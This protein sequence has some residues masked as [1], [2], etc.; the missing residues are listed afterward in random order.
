V[1]G[2]SITTPA[3]VAVRTLFALAVL[4][5]MSIGTA[6]YLRRRPADAQTVSEACDDGTIGVPVSAS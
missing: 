3:S 2:L 5:V 6:A 1:A 4:I